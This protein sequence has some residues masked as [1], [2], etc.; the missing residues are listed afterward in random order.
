MTALLADTTPRNGVWTIPAADPLDD[1]HTI[2]LGLWLGG[3]RPDGSEVVEL[4]VSFSAE[5]GILTPDEARTFAAVLIA[6][7]DHADGCTVGG[8]DA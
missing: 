2:E 4:L 8:D 3:R 7:A 6:A 5:V 1:P